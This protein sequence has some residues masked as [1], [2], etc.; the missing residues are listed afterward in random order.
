MEIDDDGLR[1]I[2]VDDEA[3]RATYVLVRDGVA[4]PPAD[5]FLQ[6]LADRNMSPNTQRR[7]PTTCGTSSASL[8]PRA[9]IGRGFVHETRQR[10]CTTSG[11]C[12]RASPDLR[13]V[14]SDSGEI[15]RLCP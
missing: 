9:T 11:T 14:S 15:G 12:G 7:T 5:R 4:L 13:P 3:R 8:L 2:R 6:F 1:V 10:C